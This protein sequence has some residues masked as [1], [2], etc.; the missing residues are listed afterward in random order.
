[1]PGLSILKA[2]WDAR[3][4]IAIGLAVAAALGLWWYVDHLQGRAEAAEARAI[5][6]EVGLNEA[7]ADA[8]ANAQAFEQLKVDNERTIAAVERERDSLSRRA[9]RVRVI[10]KEIER[11]PDSDDGPVAPVLR[12]ALDRL[13]GDG[14]AGGDEDPGRAAGG[15]GQPAQLRVLAGAPGR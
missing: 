4:L 14:A 15:P 5:R 1:M 9:A 12:R 6:L 13:R 10:V 7:V 2:A 3:G 8:S 11:A